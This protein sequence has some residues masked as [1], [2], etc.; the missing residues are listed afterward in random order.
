LAT[1]SQKISKLNIDEV[2]YSIMDNDE[3]K[4]VIV[5]LNQEQLY[6]FGVDFEGKPLKT[7]RANGGNAYSNFT[8][9]VKKEKGQP[10]DHV[11]LFD[12]GEFYKTF[13]TITSKTFSEVKGNTK[14]TDGDISD[15]LDISKI[16]GLT[17][18][19]KSELI[20]Y[21]RVPARKAFRKAMNV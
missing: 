17:T 13:S 6:V 19:S 14:V 15:N 20:Q 7:Y 21:L 8:I 3:V 10:Y 9:K 1:L 2:I 5:G 16:F 18:E 4:K 12:T 11:T